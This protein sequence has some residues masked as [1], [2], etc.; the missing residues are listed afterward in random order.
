MA[1]MKTTASA[2]S[3]PFSP[4]SIVLSLLV[5]GLGIVFSYFYSMGTESDD[6]IDLEDLPPMPGEKQIPRREDI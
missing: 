3:S 5:A 4:L 2:K 1:A 6:D